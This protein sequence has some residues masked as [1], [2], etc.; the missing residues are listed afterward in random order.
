MTMSRR[1]F[2]RAAVIL[3]FV[4]LTCLGAGA[5]TYGSY[6]PYSFFGVGDIS[7]PGT[8]YNKTMGGVG[9]AT[10]SN[11][12]INPVNPAAVTARDSLAFM[13]DFSLYGENR[14]FRQNDIKSAGNTFN[15]NDLILTFPIYGPSAMMF[16]I[17]P[18]SGTG[19]GYTYSY[20]DPSIIGKTGNITYTAK[21]QGALYQAFVAA[22]VTFFKRLSVGAQFNY[23]FGQTKKEYYETF[24][25]SSYNGAQNGFDMQLSGT[26]WKFGVQYEQPLGPTS[27]LTLGATYNLKARLGGTVE[28]YKY[29]TGSAA[30]DT[31]FYKNLNLSSDAKVYLASELGAG[32]SYS[33][34]D[35]F[36]VEFDYSRSDWRGNGFDSTMG[37]MGNTVT[38]SSRSSFKSDVAEAFRLGMEIVPNRNDIRYYLKRCAYRAGA[39][40][41]KDYFMMDGHTIGSMGITLGATLPV[42]RWYNGLTVGMEIGQRGML[43]GNLFR[44]RYINF[45]VGMNIFDV[46]FR[47]YQYE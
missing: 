33:F 20:D 26:S 37:F 43:D 21:G 36:M 30:T 23:I 7:T 46:W 3:A 16:G 45:S 15:I 4:M 11:R 39:Y 28:G 35:K 9:T 42:F 6:T 2:N 8:A 22:G 47:R 5:Q 44:E 14:Y 18:Y 41:K 34:A 27:K 32:L 38:T 40:Y 29:S 13:A 24:S 1:F 31:L 12:F 10:R 17:S 25:N 19:Y